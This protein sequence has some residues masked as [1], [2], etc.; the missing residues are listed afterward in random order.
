MV[1]KRALVPWGPN[2]LPEQDECITHGCPNKK[3]E[4]MFV[5]ALCAPCYAMITTGR[6]NPSMAWF[7]QEITMLREENRALW[8]RMEFS[9]DGE[10]VDPEEPPLKKRIGK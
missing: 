3:S 2:I 10:P 4:G 6:E 8:N 9:L 1:D 7:M 5:G